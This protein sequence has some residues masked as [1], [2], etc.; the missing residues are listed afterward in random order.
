[1]NHTERY[2]RQTMIPE[3]G[4]RGQKRLAEAKVLV[5]GVGGL[6][7]PILQYLAGAGV[8]T[9]GFIDDDL[10][11]FSNLHRQLLF[12][13]DDVGEPKV[14]VVKRWLQTHNHNLTYH[15]INERLNV[16]NAYKIITQYD[17][18]VDA[19]DNIASR[20]LINDTCIQTGKPMVYGS[21]YKF[22]GQVAV[23]N[24]KGSASYRC[25][26]SSDGQKARQ[27]DESTS[28]IVGVIPGYIA[29]LQTTEVIKMILDLGTVLTNVIFHYNLI[30]HMHYH[31]N[32]K[33]NETLIAAVKN[34]TNNFQKDYHR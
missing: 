14:E 4:E 20:Y 24:Y 27:S 28:G 18:I 13:A 7:S 15:S 6:G 8:G 25:A 21:V 16:D 3:I 22:E 31:I 30:D 29:M 9:L 26:F 11:A 19:T 17:I 2:I 5:V 32:V 12:N 23:F 34:N 1:M 10:V 33:K